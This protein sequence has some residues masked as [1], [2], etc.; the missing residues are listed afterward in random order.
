MNVDVIDKKLQQE[1]EWLRSFEINV[2]KSAQLRNDIEKVLDQFDSRLKKLEQNVMGKHEKNGRL[3]KRQQNIQRLI[4]T[5]DTT[6]QFY[7]K[8]GELETRIRDGSPTQD[9][10]AYLESIDCLQQAIAFFENY[11]EKRIQ[12]DNMKM[13]LE[14]GFDVIERDFRD[15]VSDNTIRCDMKV[16]IESLDENAELISGRVKAIQTMKSTEKMSKVATWLLSKGRD[17]RF[18]NQYSEIRSENMRQTLSQVLAEENRLRE[19]QASNRFYKGISKAAIRGERAVKETRFLSSVAHDRA[20]VAHVLFGCFLALVTVEETIMEKILNE[21]SV[22]AQVH[23]G[24]IAKPLSLCIRTAVEAMNGIDSLPSLLPL[25]RHLSTHNNQLITLASNSEMESQFEP[26]FRSL[27]IKCKSLLDESVERLKTEVDKFVPEDGNVHPLTANTL[28]LL[29]MLTIHRQTVTQQLLVPTAASP[30][31]THLLMPK[32]F[33]KILAALGAC[34]SRKAELYTDPM[35][36]SIFKINNYNYIAKSLQDEE[37]ALLPVIS[38]QNHQIL[39]FYLNEIA[40]YEQ[41]YIKSWHGVASTLS[42]VERAHDR[43]S[44]SNIV[45]TFNREFE[46]TIARQKNFC[47]ADPH[48][49]EQIREKVKKLLLTR[50]GALVERCRGEGVDQ[51]TIRYSEPTLS[52]IIDRLFDVNS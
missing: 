43:T 29:C 10:D 50:Y 44:L 8:T 52:A 31:N 5:I 7:G 41:D 48:R 35:L 15:I 27:R 26:M 18:L 13:T 14:T 25:L 12:I 9:L 37:D 39:E 49:A 20:N 23:R 17:P 4:R 19:S 32:L 6:F 1:E 46:A 11:P 24:V 45:Y 40:T 38:E 34:L 2:K 16:L 28:N 22:R 51:K 21:V 33:A 30:Q 3:Q 47:V 42:G 36:A